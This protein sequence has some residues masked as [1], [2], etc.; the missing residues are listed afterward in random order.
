[1]CRFVFFLLT[2][3]DPE[4]YTSV[5]QDLTFSPSNTRIDVSIPIVDNN[6]LEGPEDFL[7]NLRLVTTG[8]AVNVDP[9]EATINIADDDSELIIIM[10]S[11][12]LL[13]NSQSLFQYADPNPQFEET[14]YTVPEDDRTVPLCIDIGVGITTPMTYTI[15]AE[16]KSPPEAECKTETTSSNLFSTCPILFKQPQ[17]LGQVHQSQ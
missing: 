11:H 5:V 12:M 15:T 14:M 16:Q 6:V 8:A 1:M 10:K 2:Y 7:S 17:I 3:S 4:D 9:A 13:Y